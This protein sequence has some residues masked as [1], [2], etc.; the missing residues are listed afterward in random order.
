MARLWLLASLALLTVQVFAA[1]VTRKVTVDNVVR[2]ALVYPGKDADSIPSPLVFV[3][4]GF[5]GNSGNIART[6][7]LHEAW[8]E[9]T[10]VYPQGLRT[11]SKRKQRNVPAWQAELGMDGDRDLF[12]V[13]ALLADLREAYR[14]D[15]RRVYATGS[16]NGA[17]FCYILLAV[18][19]AWFAAFA[20]VAGA[21]DAVEYATVPRPVLIIHGKKDTT[22]RPEAAQHMRDV[23]LQLNGCGTAQRPWAPGYIGYEPCASGQPIIWH[24]HDGGHIWPPDATRQI[25]RFFKQHALSGQ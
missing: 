16:S 18:R 9:A 7:R 24:L 25:V 21:D 2:T 8:P 1:P 19:P 4:H 3:F 15:E 6:T 23:L 20:P 11:Y 5:T 17:M 22:V 10:V 14:V 12:F 13:D